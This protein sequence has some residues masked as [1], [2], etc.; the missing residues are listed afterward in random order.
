MF[1]TSLTTRP[2]FSCW[3]VVLSQIFRLLTQEQHACLAWLPERCRT[4]EVSHR[5]VA[6]LRQLHPRS[7]AELLSTGGI[8]RPLP[9]S[10]R[11]PS[12]IGKGGMFST[13]I[14]R[15]VRVFALQ[16]L[17]VSRRVRRP[18]SSASPSLKTPTRHSPTAIDIANRHR[19]RPPIQP[20]PSTRP[21]VRPLIQSPADPRLTHLVVR[22]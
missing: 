11:E 2:D 15:R 3:S 21:P 9:R 6:I 8:H 5:S 20:L 12:E 16:S 4:V 13:H 14:S 19:T 10:P 1:A 17:T 7:S 22:V 18:R